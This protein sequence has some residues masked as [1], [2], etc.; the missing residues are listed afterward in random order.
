V[1]LVE[2]M[3]ETAEK[4]FSLV[5]IVREG[6]AT[7]R[8]VQCE[9]D[10]DETETGREMWRAAWSLAPAGFKHRAAA[11]VG[12]VAKEKGLLLDILD[13]IL[14]GAHLED[15]EPT[16]LDE[17]D[18]AIYSADGGVLKIKGTVI[19]IGDSAAEQI[20]RGNKLEAYLG[21][22]ITAGTVLFYLLNHV[23]VGVQPGVGVS[24]IAD[25]L[26]LAVPPVPGDILSPNKTD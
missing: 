14:L 8:E 18:T 21:D 3:L 4:V 17:G 7:N 23:H 5:H 12:G 24:G 9:G 25:P 2:K 19:Y 10:R 16:D 20:V 15:G 13:G 26:T 11:A 6:S 22:T 1:R